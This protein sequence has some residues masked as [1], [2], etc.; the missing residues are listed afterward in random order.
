MTKRTDIHRPSAIDPT[1]Y[2]FV[3]FEH[4][5]IET[6]GDAI[7]NQIQR[8]RIQE[9][10]A[11]TGGTYSRHAHGGNCMVCGNANAIYTVLFYHE[12]TNTY[13]R[14]GQ[15][16]A[17]KVEA[18][19]PAEAFKKYR[20]AILA[21]EHAKAGKAKAQGVLANEGLTVAWDVYVAKPSGYEEGIIIDIVDK[22]VRYG[23]LSDKQYAYLRKLLGQIAN[24]AERDAAKKAEH[25]AAAPCPTG[26]VRIR[27]RVLSIKIVQTQFGDVA[28]MLVKAETGFK[29]YGSVPAHIQVE[30]GYLVEFDAKV[31]PSK[32]DPKFG[33]Y[34]RPTKAQVLEAAETK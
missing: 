24:R 30:R 21:A 1:D 14:M 28:K 8:Q 29:V 18:D 23:S 13:V 26:R 22:L 7:A 15:D 27:G 19:Y 32:D 4:M 6:I 12:K 11:R 31:E 25:D 3:G 33:F 9:H 34:S 17:E 20:D 2:D 5:K 10:M 16:C